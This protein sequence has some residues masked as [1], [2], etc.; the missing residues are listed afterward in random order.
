VN[1]ADFPLAEL[2]RRLAERATPP[3]RALVTALLADPRAGVRALGAALSRARSRTAAD[4]R[5]VGWL[6]RTE[7]ALAQSEEIVAGVDEA[8]TGP[9]AGP[10]VASAVV[11]PP[12]ARFSGLD[13]SKRV[14]P[15]DRARLDHEIR[16]QALAVSLGWASV[17]EIDRWNILQASLVAM[18]RAVLGLALR[19]GVLLVDA[20][21]VPGVELPQRAVVGGDGRVASIAAASIVAKVY[22]DA[23]MRALDRRHPGYGFDHNAGYGTPDHLA[24]LEH[25]GPSPVHRLSFAPVRES[26]RG[27]VD[28]A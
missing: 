4:H 10:V 5:R 23:W 1:P 15:A 12:G 25:L 14:A 21:T 28:T 18:R 22:R 7:R 8:G 19:P 16:A 9:L 6:F 20:R 24:A 2:R 3:S 27:A 11:L 17:E 26:K 13:D